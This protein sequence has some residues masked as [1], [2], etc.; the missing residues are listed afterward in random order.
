MNV[1]SYTVEINTDN[2]RKKIRQFTADLVILLGFLVL[3]FTIA[4]FSF[5]AGRNSAINGVTGIEKT[6]DSAYVVEY[7]GEAHEYFV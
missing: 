5:K 4:F 1:K 7:D 3:V 2:L 6:G